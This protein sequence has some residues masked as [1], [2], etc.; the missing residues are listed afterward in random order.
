MMNA[1]SESEEEVLYNLSNGKQYI[2]LQNLE[3]SHVS[4]QLKPGLLETPRTSGVGA[5]F[6]NLFKCYTGAGLLSLPFAFRYSGVV[7]GVVCLILVSVMCTV[8]MVCLVKCKIHLS[9]KSSANLTYSDVVLLLLGRKWSIVLDITI[10]AFQFGAVVIYFVFVSE[11][12]TPFFS[13]MSSISARWCWLLFIAPLYIG[14]SW[15]RSMKYIGIISFFAE[16]SILT[17]IA[18]TG[19]IGCL[20]LSRK[21]VPGLAFNVNMTPPWRTLPLM[22]GMA[23]FAFE[24]AGVVIPS[25]CSM[26]KPEKFNKVLVSVLSAATFMYITFGVL[27][28]TAFGPETGFTTGQI[29]E[30][31]EQFATHM[32]D[33]SFWHVMQIVVRLCLVF[34]IGMSVSVQLI[35]VLDIVEKEL[36]KP[37]RFSQNNLFWKQNLIRAVMTVIGLSLAASGLSFG[38]L[39]SLTGA[40]SGT[41]MQ[42]IFPAACYLKCFRDSLSLC[43]KLGMWL[44]AICGVIFGGLATYVTLIEMFS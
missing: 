38:H 18:V 36:F 29:T 13:K 12:L 43:Q 32:V 39:V 20:Q 25:E 1:E 40:F 28:Y 11:N 22:F 44:L 9:K 19:V 30:N 3:G 4:P 6:A 33:R 27:L 42:F 35:V 26:K 24:G 41:L 37:G 23:A 2:A 17:G 14:L 5:I 31:L 15:I 16:I 7:A 10:I 34:G 21:V 8:S